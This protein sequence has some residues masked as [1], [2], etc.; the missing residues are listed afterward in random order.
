[1]TLYSLDIFLPDLE[2]VCWGK[3]REEYQ[4]IP[5]HFS[6]FP[7]STLDF[8]TYSLTESKIGSSWWFPEFFT[9]N[10]TKL[11][12]P[13]H[14]IH[15]SLCWDTH[16]LLLKIFGRNY[17]YIHIELNSNSTRCIWWKISLCVYFQ[18][19]WLLSFLLRMIVVL[20]FTMF[21]KSL[22]VCILEMIPCL[23]IKCFPCF[24]MEAHYSIVC[25]CAQS[26]PTLWHHGL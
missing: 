22:K 11:L 4:K 2:P 1:M 5:K 19:T 21:F 17:L 12:N 6:Y 7:L 26:C 24:F 18:V 25:V 13:Y 14:K 8:S 20:F 10:C 3:V 23:Y 9:S 15:L 16:L